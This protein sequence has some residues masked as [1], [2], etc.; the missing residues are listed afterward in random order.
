MISE[1]DGQSAKTVLI[2]LDRS[3]HRRSRRL[4]RIGRRRIPASPTVDGFRLRDASRRRRQSRRQLGHSGFFLHL[5]TEDY[6]SR[7]YRIQ[8]IGRRQYSSRLPHRLLFWAHLA[9]HISERA[10]RR[11]VVVLLV[12]LSLL[13]MSHEFAQDSGS[14][15]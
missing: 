5:S 7:R 15:N 9:T 3:R 4:D 6:R 1:L 12:M 11:M 13:L 10:L 14:A 2:F 8:P